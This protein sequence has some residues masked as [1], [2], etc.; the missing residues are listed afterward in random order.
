M[1]Q[2]T[3][4]VNSLAHYLG[5][6]PFDDHRSPRD[7]FLTALITL[8]EGYHNFHHEFP[9]DYRNGIEWYQFDITKWIIKMF[10]CLSLASN[11]KRFRESEIEKG[12][13]QQMFK[14]LNKRS[15]TLDWGKQLCELPIMEWNE[16][17]RLVNTEGQLLT[18]V[19]GVVHDVSGFIDEHPGGK[20][21]IRS[22]LGKDATSSFNGT[23]YNHSNAARNLLQT[24]R[25]AVLRGGCEIE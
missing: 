11:L 13:I 17:Q 10:E 9:S 20:L 14:R 21:M 6:Q 12:R 7:H 24:L 22:V 5:D 18:V 8:G 4:C 1:N 23:I 16:Y 25:V 19:E 2:A 3:F 15:S